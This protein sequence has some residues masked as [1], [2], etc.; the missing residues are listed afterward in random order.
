MRTMRTISLLLLLLWSVPARAQQPPDCVIRMVATGTGRSA[1]T[2]TQGDNR[3]PG[4]YNW[5]L[6]VTATGFSGI[7][8]ELDDAQDS[9]GIPSTWNAFQGSL[10]NGATQPVTSTT[11]TLLAM[12]GYFPWMSV[13]VNSVT[14]AGSITITAYGWRYWGTSLNNSSSSGV[15]G[16]CSTA[17]ADA[18]FTSS[19]VLA[20]G[21]IVDTGSAMTIG[22]SAYNTSG[23][24]FS[25]TGPVIN[26]GTEKFGGTTSSFPSVSADATYGT[27]L[28]FK[29]AD[30]S[31]YT[32][33][34]YG[35]AVVTLASSSTITPNTDEYD[36]ITT[37]NTA[38]T[39]TLTVNAPSPST[40]ND[41]D[42]EW[43]RIKST[44]VQT[45]SWNAIYQGSTTQAL[46]T[47]SSGS[48]LWDYILFQYNAVTSKWDML[49]YNA[50]FSQ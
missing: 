1:V 8:V 41:G 47:T 28:D 36:G 3:L 21:G 48:L 6:S 38:G 16:S 49:A 42:Q 18:K 5:A 30:G 33:I 25:G 23:Y 15:T 12:T 31:A 4:C 45:Y 39:G 11:S 27:Q 22:G 24:T 40:P 50:G 44:N 10:L 32:R 17:N 29:L 26:G 9:G 13:N 2:S 34:R 20:C 35:K 46:P 19:T 43:I 37:T 7:S 14:G